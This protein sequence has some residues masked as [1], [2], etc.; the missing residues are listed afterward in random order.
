MKHLTLMP[1]VSLAILA[2]IMC[3]GTTL[4]AQ[5]T[6]WSSLNLNQKFEQL[7]VNYKKD[8]AMEDSLYNFMPEDEWK[9]LYQRRIVTYRNIHNEDD[10]II[11][12]IYNYYKYSASIPRYQYDSLLVKSSEFYRQTRDP[13]ITEHLISFALPQYS[14]LGDM[15]HLFQCNA[16][17]GLALT[18][19]AR[20]GEHNE[21][22]NAIDYLNQAADWGFAHYKDFRFTDSYDYLT[23]VY[24][25]LLQ[26]RW[27]ELR[28][29]TIDNCY[30]RYLELQDMNEW[31]KNNPDNT[32]VDEKVRSRTSSCYFD[33]EYNLLGYIMNEKSPFNSNP[34]VKL[35][36][37]FVKK[38]HELKAK[39]WKENPV[40][41]YQITPQHEVLYQESLHFAGLKSPLQTFQAID[42]IYQQLKSQPKLGSRIAELIEYINKAVFFMDLSDEM[43]YGTK[44]WYSTLY[45]I[46]L[47]Q[48]AKLGRVVRRQ[49]RFYDQ[50]EALI[51][52]PHFYKYLNNDNRQDLIHNVLIK[53]D[54][55]T[56]AHSTLVTWIAW[57]ILETTINKKPSLL[58]GTLGYNSLKQVQEHKNQLHEYLWNASMIHDLGLTRMAPTTNRHYR[59]LTSH[60]MQLLRRHSPNG[61]AIINISPVGM[62]YYDMIQGHHKWYNGKGYPEA[63]DNINSPYHTM[64]DI[65][66]I[67]DF[68]EGGAD[69]PYEGGLQGF[70]G[71]L[72]TLRKMAGTQFNPELVKII[73]EEDNLAVRLRNLCDEG[74]LRSRYDV[75]KEYFAENK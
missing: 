52:N 69:L 49:S 3:F 41:E 37:K 46:D 74:Q 11:N 25:E 6:S 50:L 9:Q 51:T 54:A 45:L 39:L 71:R 14:K 47:M 23:R 34:E 42:S 43:E 40:F 60:E 75:F 59:S 63:F 8:L 2:C 70:D 28:K 61:A 10:S 1:S 53:T 65:L 68:L 48:F 20:E 4:S 66:T 64:I 32:K 27:L 73:L 56:Y 38:H 21:Y 55:E 12:A 36:T 33:F 58:L 67:A 16:V 35:L 31:F 24:Q 62:R 29:Q 5:T 72:E 19:I 17:M 15:E 57:N 7:R 44:Q 18:Q 30:S 22:L 26:V 13:F